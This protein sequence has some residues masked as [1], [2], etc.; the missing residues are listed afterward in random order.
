MKKLIL[1]TG[2]ELDFFKR[3][4]MIAK[5]ADLGQPIPE[6]KIISFEDPADA[7][8]LEVMNRSGDTREDD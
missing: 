6:E 3:G 7:T 8:N 2:T 4:R 5:A 1:K